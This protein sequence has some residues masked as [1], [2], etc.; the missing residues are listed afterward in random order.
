[1][2]AAMDDAVGRVL[3]RL[4]ERG[5]EQRTLVFFLSDNGG[6]TRQTTA[7]N[8]PLRGFKGRVYEGGIRVPFLV[9][10]PDRLD[11]G[12]VFEH[13][14]TSLDIVAT[15]LA[16]AGV[17][18]GSGLDGEDLAPYLAGKRDGAPHEAVFWRFGRQSAVRMGDWKL[19]R[20][21]E[22]TELYHVRDDPAETLEVS[23]LFPDTVKRLRAAYAA[24]NA[25]MVP[26][27]WRRSPRGRR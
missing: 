14:V 13:P 9:R 26:P 10:W 25:E 23:T 15:A 27:R 6:P 12:R 7:R 24:W 16:A 3:D 22:A 2:V 20:T 4:R 11:G 1:M 21:A 5:L 17:E 8:D 19:I 18:T